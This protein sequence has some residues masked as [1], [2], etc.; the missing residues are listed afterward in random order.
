MVEISKKGAHVFVTKNKW[1]LQTNRNKNSIFQQNFAI[2]KNETTINVINFYLIVSGVENFSLKC[3]FLV[4][5]FNLANEKNVQLVD[6]NVINFVE[7]RRRRV[8]SFL[9]EISILM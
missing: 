4:F 6:Y 1:K 9:A 8:S 7:R 5:Y 2:G 3:G